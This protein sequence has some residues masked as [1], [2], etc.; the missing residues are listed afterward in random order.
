MFLERRDAV[1]GRW[2]LYASEQEHHADCERYPFNEIPARV[3]LD[4]C[5]VNL[6]VKNASAIFEGG[7]INPSTPANQGREIEA[8]LHL[9]AV[10]AQAQWS[11]LASETSLAEVTRTPC[12]QMREELQSYV[13]E[14]IERLPPSLQ[15][16]DEVALGTAR[17]GALD[18]LPDE[19]DRRL[20]SH[21]VAFGCDAFATTDVKTIISKRHQLS[22][23]PLRILTPCEWWRHV[24]PWGR[25]WL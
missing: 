9:F 10:G 23:L 1:S 13:Y 2:I 16:Q 21:A 7:V 8:L 24:K 3:F 17:T 12:E 11:L 5:V 22:P 20:I 18:A 6:I 15:S 14:L 25:L 4:T 19:G